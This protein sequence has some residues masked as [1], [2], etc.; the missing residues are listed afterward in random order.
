MIL[1]SSRIGISSLL[2]APAWDT[3]RLTRVL[4]GA[5]SV[6]ES[7]T[8]ANSVLMVTVKSLWVVGPAKCT[9]SETLSKAEASGVVLSKSTLT[10]PA[11]ILPAVNTT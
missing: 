9:I 7:I 3:V 5:Q 10:V 4:L 2:K 11:L 8:P 1:H 6:A